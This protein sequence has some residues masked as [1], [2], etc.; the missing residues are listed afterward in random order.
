V[1]NDTT[2]TFEHTYTWWGNQ[3]KLRVARQPNVT[4]G[5]EHVPPR[6]RAAR[7][8][9]LGPLTPSDINVASFAAYKPGARRTFSQHC[10]LKPLTLNPKQA[11]CPSHL[12]S[13]HTCALPGKSSGAYQLVR[14]ASV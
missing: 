14:A 2:L 1:I 11:R 13:T 3:R 8:V 9:L 4:L 6:C 7:V 12:F 10:H 5:L